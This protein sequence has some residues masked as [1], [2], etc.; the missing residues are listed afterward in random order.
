MAATDDIIDRH[1]HDKDKEPNSEFGFDNMKYVLNEDSDPE[2]YRIHSFF[3]D[4]FRS[5]FYYNLKNATDDKAAPDKKIDIIKSVLPLDAKGGDR[6]SIREKIYD[7][8]NNILL[9]TNNLKLLKTPIIL[10]VDNEFFYDLDDAD[11]DADADVDADLDDAD[12]KPTLE[13]FFKNTSYNYGIRNLGSDENMDNLIFDK[14]IIGKYTSDSVEI[15]NPNDEEKKSS[16]FLQI[17]PDNFEQAIG[18]YLNLRFKIFES[19]EDG[20]ITCHKDRNQLSSIYNPNYGTDK[21]KKPYIF[22]F[23]ENNCNNTHKKPIENLHKFVIQEINDD[24]PYIIDDDGKGILKGWNYGL[25]KQNIIMLIDDLKKSI[26]LNITSCPTLI[27][28]YGNH[29]EFI[30][31]D[32]LIDGWRDKLTV[33][34]E[35]VDENTKRWET[36]DELKK[37]LHNFAMYYKNN[38]PTTAVEQTTSAAEKENEQEQEQEQ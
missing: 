31:N 37:K 14:K 34:E 21:N 12:D 29:Y 6:K 10:L 38:K 4:K 1:G 32:T 7:Y 16:L 23:A 20:F 15:I 19:G 33:K 35:I 8:F 24:D 5:I 9:N 25:D 13:S 27:L 17:S 26:S 2:N 18:S 11:A 28:Q 22:I 36:S 30:H 3:N